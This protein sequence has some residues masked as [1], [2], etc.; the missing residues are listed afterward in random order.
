MKQQ[1]VARFAV[2]SSMQHPAANLANL[3][4]LRSKWPVA[5]LSEDQFSRVEPE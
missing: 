2:G 1:P 3:N 5:N 4:P